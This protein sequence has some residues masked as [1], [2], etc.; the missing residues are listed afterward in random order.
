MSG[1]KGEDSS[2]LHARLSSCELI[3]ACAGETD[4]KKVLLVTMVTSRPDKLSWPDVFISQDIRQV[5]IQT[6][7]EE[8]HQSWNLQ[9][10]SVQFAQPPCFYSEGFEPEVLLLLL[11]DHRRV[12]KSIKLWKIPLIA[13]LCHRSSWRNGGSPDVVHLRTNTWHPMACLPSF[14]SIWVDR[15]IYVL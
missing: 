12:R 13:F 1:R 6:Y 11:L 9:P 7:P 10:A 5:K 8:G 4:D 14:Q 2:T 15:N 3:E